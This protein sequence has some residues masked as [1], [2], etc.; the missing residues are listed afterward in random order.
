[1]GGFLTVGNLVMAVWSL[2]RGESMKMNYWLRG[3]VAMQGLTIVALLVGAV[4][5][6]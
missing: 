5:Y 2:A 4:P 1:T 6:G 3:R